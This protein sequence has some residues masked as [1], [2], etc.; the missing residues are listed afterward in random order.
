MVGK[1]RGETLVGLVGLGHDQQAGRI[2]VQ[3]MDDSGA[4][5]AA[6]ARQAVAAMGD[7]RIDEGAG[8]MARR[9]VDHEAGRLV[10]DDEVLVL[11]NDRE[12]NVLA[13]RLGGGGLGHVDRDGLANLHLG[14]G[15]RDGLA[16]HL[17]MAGLHQRLDAR[18]RQAVAGEGEEFVEPAG[19]LDREGVAAR[20]QARTQ[21]AGR[22]CDDIFGLFLDLGAE[23]TELVAT[24]GMLVHRG[25][26]ARVC[27]QGQNKGG[28]GRAARRTSC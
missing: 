14:A 22:A 21:D 23:D 26:I 7:E 3:T 10:D 15:V 5:H 25:S 17:H 20:R 24:F 12:R 4:A 13:L 2:L 27:A 9:R 28:Q 1:E 8:F 11:E 19:F 16:L 6:N 18:A